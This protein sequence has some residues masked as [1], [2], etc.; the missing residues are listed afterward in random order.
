MSEVVKF[1]FQ[2]S[3]TNVL[4]SSGQCGDDTG[5]NLRWMV[6]TVVNVLVSMSGFAV[7]SCLE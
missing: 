2:S 7:Y 6:G 3:G 1:F 4:G 5:F